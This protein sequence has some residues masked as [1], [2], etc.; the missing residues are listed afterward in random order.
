MEAAHWLHLEQ[1]VEEIR[2]MQC[3]HSNAA[4]KFFPSWDDYW[5]IAD[6]EETD[7]ITCFVIRPMGFVT[8]IFTVG[9]KYK[10]PLCSRVGCS[11]QVKCICF[12]K[13]KLFM[14]DGES[15]EEDESRMEQTCWQ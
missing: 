12:K 15:E 5:T 1:R 2:G 10:F 9:R 11:R 4:M 3:V 6:I 13:Y 7:H 14:K 8:L